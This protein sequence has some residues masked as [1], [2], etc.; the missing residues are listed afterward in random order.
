MMVQ[1][2]RPFTSTHP[3]DVGDVLDATRWPA[4]RV[5]QLT[6][7]RY[8]TPIVQLSRPTDAGSV[9]MSE[10]ARRKRGRPR[11]HPEQEVQA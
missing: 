4:N 8:V 6:K 9:A 10:P 1:V 5:R 3:H 7:L 11:K 2:L